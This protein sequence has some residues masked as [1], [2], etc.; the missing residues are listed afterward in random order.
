MTEQQESEQKQAF[1]YIRVSSRLQSFGQSLEEQQRQINLYAD[2]SKLTIIKEYV[3][4]DSASE[5]DRPQFGDM[6]KQLRKKEVL[7]VIFHSVDRSARNPY[8]QATL[9]ELMTQGYTYHFVGE[10]MSTN[11]HA[12]RSMLMILW[13]MASSFTENLKFHVNKGIEGMLRDGRSPTAAPIGYL[14]AGRGVKAPD[15]RYAHL[16]RKTFELYSTGTY[17]IETLTEKMEKLGLRNKQGQVLKPKAMYKIL[18]KRFYHGIITYRNQDYNGS[19]ETII[20]KALFDKVQAVM[21][22]K[23][24][25]KIR[26][27]TYIFQQLIPCPTCNQ[28]M[29][30]VSAKKIYKYYNCRDKKC[31]FRSSIRETEIEYLFLTE[32]KKLE[33]TDA[34]AEIFLKAVSTLRADL[35]STKATELTHLDLEEAKLQKKLEMLLN[36]NLEDEI[37]DEEFR[38]MKTG[39]VNRRAEIQHRRRALDKAD[40]DTLEKI[41]E[42]GKLLKQ[43]YLAY[44]QASD[45]NKRRL[46]KSMLENTQWDQENLQIHWKKQ[47]KLVA[48]RNKSSVG[49]PCGRDLEPNCS[50]SEGLAGVCHELA[51]QFIP[52][53]VMLSVLSLV[54]PG[55][56]H[57]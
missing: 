47:F 11:N 39:F 44:V 27:F 37:T 48:E 46:V 36:K 4:V 22:K 49:S 12:A 5:L 20:T 29:R 56:R 7:N 50:R 34:E 18:R 15:P 31:S 25:K 51:G 35:Q 54:S 33:F 42:I 28:P 1:S 2:R 53:A 40:E 13:G 43:P 8:D 32:L 23:S 38:T 3:E 52:L 41:A 55:D 30:S 19:H 16:V 14:D 24:Y 10:G 45:E 21:D 9:Y 57:C 6:I 26:T 17:D